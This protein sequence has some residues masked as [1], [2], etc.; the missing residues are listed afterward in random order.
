V[1]TQLDAGR[2]TLHDPRCNVDVTVLLGNDVAVRKTVPG[3]SADLQ[4]NVQLTVVGERQPDGSIK[5]QTVTIVSPT[6]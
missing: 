2:L 4:A 3:G 6:R 5:A 1:V